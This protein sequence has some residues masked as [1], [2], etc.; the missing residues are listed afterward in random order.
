[1]PKGEKVLSPKQKDRTTILNF[2]QK[3]KEEII[4]F[5][6]SFSLKIT[7]SIKNFN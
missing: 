1:M 6:I 7:I 3:L 5:G 4:S 2:S